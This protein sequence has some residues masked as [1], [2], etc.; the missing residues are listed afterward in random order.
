M[1]NAERQQLYR[2]RNPD[3]IKHRNAVS[4]QSV[5]SD[6]VKLDARRK[7]NAQVQKEWRARNRE[8]YLAAQKA[9]RSTMEG[10]CRHALHKSKHQ[11]KKYNHEPCNAS[12]TEL[13]EAF[14]G[15]CCVCGAEES[16]PRLSMDHDHQTG[17]FRGWLCYKC[18]YVLGLVDDNPEILQDLSHYLEK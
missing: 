18:N 4:Y 17:D 8:Q 11:A 15:R 9:Y 3:K 2:Q 6:P 5:K 12:I 10:R 16:E 1:T 13:I 7:A 14:T